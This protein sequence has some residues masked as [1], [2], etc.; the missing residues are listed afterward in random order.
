MTI[1]IEK[2]NIFYGRRQA[3]NEVSC[4]AQAGAITVVVG[5]NASGKSTLLRAIAGLHRPSQ[6]RV[7]VQRRDSFR[8]IS[9]LS[10][11]KRAA[12]L[13]YVAQRPA[14]SARFSVRQ[15]VSL[16]R[17]ALTR[18]EER[19]DWALDMMKIEEEL[20][21]R[22]YAELSVGQQQLVAV[23]RAL[24]QIAPPINRPLDASDLCLVLDEPTA[25]LDLKHVGVVRHVARILADAG[26]TVIL[27]LHDLTAAAQIGDHAWLLSSGQIA[28]TGPV[29]EIFE[30]EHLAEVFGC[31]FR[32]VREI[33]GAQ[34]ILPA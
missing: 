26:A 18:S 21:E 20:F 8:S 10:P 32:L 12:Q 15:V 16:G 25:A 23:A 11:R 1:R 30:P 24:A 31:G 9:R 7:L 3:L 17:Y 14:V 33:G 6:G 34:Y 27:A 2:L 29:E 19:I 22:P 5:P 28:A 13:A 4:Q